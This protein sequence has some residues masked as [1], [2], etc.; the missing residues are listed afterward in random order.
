VRGWGGVLGRRA[1]DVWFRI[2]GSRSGLWGV[3]FRVE[4]FGIGLQ[5]SCFRV[6]GLVYR[7]LVIG[8]RDQGPGCRI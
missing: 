2:Y 8:F 7:G 4:V 3:G 5:G 6:Y 1:Q